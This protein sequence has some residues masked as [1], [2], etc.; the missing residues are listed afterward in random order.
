MIKIVL[1]SNK[2]ETPYKST[3][4]LEKNK[5]QISTD[6]SKS[7]YYNTVWNIQNSASNKKEKRIIANLENNYKDSDHI[8]RNFY[9]VSQTEIVR[10]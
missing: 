4:K 7:A 3:L 2:Q 5:L 8:V 1:E 9:I 6:T 10:F